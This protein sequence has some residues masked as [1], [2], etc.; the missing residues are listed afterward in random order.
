MLGTLLWA[1][2]AG[3]LALAS[4]GR[5]RGET[6]Q[7]GS[8]LQVRLESGISSYSSKPG[9]PLAGVLIAPL[10]DGAHILLPMG[11]RV[12]GKLKAVR[13]VGLGFWH[14][15]ARLQ[16][17]FSRVQLPS[18]EWLAIHSRLV[19]VENAR[20]RVDAQGVIRG[21]RATGTLSNRASNLINAGA[22]LDPIAWAFSMASSASLMR[23]SEPEILLPAG[24]EVRLRVLESVPLSVQAQAPERGVSRDDDD[25]RSLAHLVRA[26]PYRTLTLKSSRPSD[27]TNVVLLGG[28]EAIERAFEAAG[29]VAPDART[30][31]TIYRTFRAIT[32]DQGY[33]RAPMSQQLLAGEDP[34]LSVSKTLNTFSR[35]HH[36][37]IWHRPETWNAQDV[38]VAAGTEDVAV[39]FSQKNRT[40]IHVINEQIDA[41]R[42]KIVNDLSFTGC[43]AGVER[44]ERPWVPRLT[45]NA[46]GDRM[47]TDGAVVVLKL[48]E[49]E[50]PRRTASHPSP[51]QS[52]SAVQRGLRQVSLK[53]RDSAIR[54]NLFYQGFEGIRYLRGV[55]SG[56]RVKEPDGERTLELDGEEFRASTGL[57]PLTAPN[58]VAPVRGT[59]VGLKPVNEHRWSPAYYELGVSLGLT[60]YA[61]ASLDAVRMWIVPLDPTQPAE[62]VTLADQLGSGWAAGITVVHH[63]YRHVSNEFGY[64]YQRGTYRLDAAYLTGALKGTS[65]SQPETGLLTRQFSYSLLG[66]L[67]PR[68]QRLRPY[69]AAGP[70]VQLINLTDAPVEHVSGP[71]ILGMRNVGLIKAAYNFGTEAP[72][73]GGGLFQFGVQYGGGVRYRIHPRWTLGL[74]YRETAGPAPDIIAKSLPNGRTT[75]ETAAVNV[76]QLRS[77]GMFR[78]RR[79]TLSFAFTF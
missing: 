24:T 57:P 1:A 38:F 17:E 34:A 65:K 30:S 16:L 58:L 27:I 21:I 40:F 69:V 33:H 75:V 4:I 74:D 23:F 22:M 54:G 61:R 10:R 48:N 71:W 13:R 5:L 3:L 73:N 2:L 29:W 8:V 76:M 52:G 55:L 45:R 53:V 66:Q 41:E 36:A 26:L 11:C 12:D 42:E 7:A 67:R 39:A 43:V 35:R 14:E 50:S 60:S 77:G 44:V 68:G 15:T 20:E 62:K 9:T 28:K 72:L 47:A 56:T 63:A 37:R 49:C 25:R 59:R 64:T 46:T 6:L 51:P 31:T 18:G 19:E 78:Q 79:G 32:E 70:V